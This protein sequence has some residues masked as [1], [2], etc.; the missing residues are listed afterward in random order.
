MWERVHK[1]VGMENLMVYI[2]TEPDFVRQVLRR[3]MDFQIGIAER[4]LKHGV[5]MTFM[6]DDLGAQSSLLLSPA[7]VDEFLLP[8]YRRI[9]DLY[10]SN[11][12]LINFHSCGHVEPLLGMLME[13][14]A[15]IINPVQ[16]TANNLQSV[17]EVTQGKMSLCGGISTHLLMISSIEEIVK[18]TKETLYMLGAK[19]GYI[20]TPDQHMPF[21]KEKVDAFIQ[22][23]EEYGR[24]P[25]S[26][27]F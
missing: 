11:G 12:V 5:E 14:G 25:I 13:L 24:Y 6:G 20:C 21:E 9:F 17:R 3:I 10:K 27:V 7:T 22:T 2:Y 8:E 4:Y 18:M 23:V 19:G 16:A 1:L 26:P 15:D